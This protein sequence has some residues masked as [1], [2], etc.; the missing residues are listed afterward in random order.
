MVDF[1]KQFRLLE[2]NVQRLGN[3]IKRGHRRANVIARRLKD[4]AA[5]EGPAA[6]TVLELTRDADDVAGEGDEDADLETVD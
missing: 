5:L 6:A 3:N 1:G 4:V 2:D